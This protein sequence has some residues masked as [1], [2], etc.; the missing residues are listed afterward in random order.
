MR[1]ID[2]RQKPL[3]ESFFYKNSMKTIK[4]GYI[5]ND[6]IFKGLKNK[7]ILIKNENSSI[8]F[9]IT[10]CNISEVIAAK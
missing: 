4:A 7:F 1:A 5:S 9:K 6:L 10:L 2:S 3:R 8:K